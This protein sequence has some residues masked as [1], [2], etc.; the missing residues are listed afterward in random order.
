MLSYIAR[1]VSLDMLE[2]LVMLRAVA[3][4]DLGAGALGLKGLYAN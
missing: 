3:L 2:C 1:L 4:G